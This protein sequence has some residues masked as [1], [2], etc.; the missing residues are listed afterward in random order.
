MFYLIPRAV[1]YDLDKSSD[2]DDCDSQVSNKTLKRFLKKKN[3]KKQL[4][5]TKLKKEVIKRA[6]IAIENIRKESHNLV[7]EKPQVFKDFNKLSRK[8]SLSLPSVNEI[9]GQVLSDKT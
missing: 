4:A 7:E 9:R 5:Y 3:D 6:N 1:S 8:R 2:D